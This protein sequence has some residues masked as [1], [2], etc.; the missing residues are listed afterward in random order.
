MP[1]IKEVEI[2]ESQSEAAAAYEGTQ[3]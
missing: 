1:Y 2:L 3:Q